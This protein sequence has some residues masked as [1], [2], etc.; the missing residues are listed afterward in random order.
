V[1]IKSGN[2]A[3]A[4]AALHAGISGA[5]AY[6]G[7][8]S[9]EIMTNVIK[10]SDLG[11]WCVNEKVSLE[12]ALG[13]SYA[14]G[15]SFVAMKHV[16]LNASA[17][18]FMSGS[19]CKINGGIVIIV[20]DDP[21]MH[22]SQNE[23][24]SRYYVDFAKIPCLEPS[25]IQEVYDMV[26]DGYEISEELNKPVIVR[27][28]TRLSHSKGEL[29]SGEVHSKVMKPIASFSDWNSVP[30]FSKVSWIRTLSRQ[31]DMEKISELSG[32]NYAEY[33]SK[34]KIG[35]I[36]SGLAREYYLE[37]KKNLPHLHI[38]MYPIPYK[39][40]REFC[41]NLEEIF[42]VEEGY[43][44]IE[45]YLR[46]ILPVKQKIIGKID[47]SLPMA[48]ELNSDLVR[49]MLEPNYTIPKLPETEFKMAG[50]PPQLC[51]GCPHSDTFNLLKR[52][53]EEDKDV[54]INGDIGCYSL[55][56]LPP[57]SVPMTLVDMGASIPMAIGSCEC[58][59][60]GVAVI[61]DG[62]F[63]HSGLTGLVECVAHKIPITLIILD[64]QTT[65][66]TGGQPQILPSERIVEIV[67]GI[68]VLEE[69]V[70]TYVPLPNH[71]EENLKL[72]RKEIAYN[73]VSVLIAKRECIETLRKRS[74]S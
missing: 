18:P 11:T 57:Y 74:K 29:K 44:F 25:T 1:E 55:G 30:A 31:D 5:Y 67:K 23:Q 34:S 59:K 3:A 68:G 20:A 6:P 39:K 69:R 24:D 35:V 46:G 28:C 4:L 26:V 73:G 17:D 8:P 53:I 37:L 47:G 71:H 32:Y 7:T 42:V 72:L 21:G 45:R 50:R 22:S 56:S 58:G 2:E 33:P 70:I 62:T 38:G 49:K 40:I 63:M 52:I 12:I 41:E 16:G 27:M 13:V 61:G 66:M 54:I 60:K 36:T 64:N 51:N 65:A 9:T 43:P 19:L 15:R 14:G 48:G 10:L